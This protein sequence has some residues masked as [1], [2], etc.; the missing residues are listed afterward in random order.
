MKR[1]APSRLFTGF[2]LV[3]ACGL[4]CSQTHAGPYYYNDMSGGGY[5]SGSSTGHAYIGGMAGLVF[6]QKAEV[7]VKIKT[8]GE[9]AGVNVEGDTGGFAGL[10]LGWM[11]PDSGLLKFAVEGEALYFSAAVSGGDTFRGRDLSYEGDLSAI[12][13][14]LNG[15]LRFDLGAFE[16]YAGLGLGPVR[17]TIKDPLFHVDDRLQR[18]VGEISDWGWAWQFML[19]AEL[20]LF[21][22]RLGLFTEYKYFSL[23]SVEQLEQYR[24][25]MLGLGLRVHF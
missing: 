8:R 9:N 18:G 21:S 11:F 5:D 25:H 7:E 20:M 3:A 12:A 13:L 17:A 6:P 24:Q 10:K 23:L 16:P 4:F 22:D 2:A 15:F 14:M 1:L 19:G